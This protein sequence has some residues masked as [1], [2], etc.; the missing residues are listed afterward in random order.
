MKNNFLSSTYHFV[1]SLHNSIRRTN[2]YIC[3]ANDASNRERW[4]REKRGYV[5]DLEAPGSRFGALGTEPWTP[6]R[7]IDRPLDTVQSKVHRTESW[8]GN[9]WTKGILRDLDPRVPPGLGETGLP[10]T[11]F[12]VLSFLRTWR[13]RGDGTAKNAKARSSAS[14]SLSLSFLRRERQ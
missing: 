12:V 14:L 9:S 1:S 5:M 2:F 7:T 4:R 11:F 3:V 8:P 6:K 10:A 13:F